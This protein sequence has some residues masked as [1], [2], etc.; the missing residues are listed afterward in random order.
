M[1]DEVSCKI[2]P[3]SV[4]TTVVDLN[5]TGCETVS[6]SI[7]GE[8]LELE[9]FGTCTKR[10]HEMLL[11]LMTGC[12]AANKSQELFCGLSN[13][14]DSF[15]APCKV[16]CFWES[17]NVCI[18][19]NTNNMLD[20]PG[21]GAHEAIANVTHEHSG[22]FCNSSYHNLTVLLYSDNSSRYLESCLDTSFNFNNDTVG[23]NE[24]SNASSVC[25]S[26]SGPP[27][28]CFWNPN[29]RITGEYCPRCEPL[30]RSSDHSLNFIQFAVG[31]SSITLGFIMSRIAF[32]LLT[33]DAMGAASQVSVM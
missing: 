9:Y 19:F 12:L 23:S 16:D 31:V 32:T 5:N 30:C 26:F 11:A 6:N 18:T 28:N 13:A 1:L 17:K 24:N 7:L 2:T 22:V 25:E 10:S 3:E 15:Y 14:E 8:P 29:S 21:S 27:Y 4:H 33:S 20:E